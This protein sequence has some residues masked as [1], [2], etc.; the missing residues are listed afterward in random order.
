MMRCAL[1]LF[2]LA[3]L[4]GCAHRSDEQTR[5]PAAVESRVVPGAVA[6][7][8]QLVDR[9]RQEP[10]TAAD[11]DARRALDRQARRITELEPRSPEVEA[12]QVVDLIAYSQRLSNMNAD[13]QGRELKEATQEHAR[14]P[15]LYT[16]TRL[17]LVLASPG[18]AV[19]DDGKAASLLEAVAAQPARSPLRQFAALVHGLLQ[20]RVRD[21]RR[22]SQLREQIDGL[23]A[24]DRSLMD[25]EQGRAQ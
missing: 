17:A 16:R 2:G 11:A 5:P 12:R 20:E 9:S 25:R 14:E 21:Q 19:N 7:N 15:S 23:R 4:A 1:S 8:R 13:Q 10:R 6:S 3:L 18:G 24:I 22:V